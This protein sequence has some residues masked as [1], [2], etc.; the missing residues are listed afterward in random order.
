MCPEVNFF[1]NKIKKLLRGNTYIFDKC[2]VEKSLFLDILLYFVVMDH[3]NRTYNS[4]DLEK[5]SNELKVQTLKQELEILNQ[6]CNFLR[7]ELQNYKL[8]VN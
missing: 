6:E 4:W 8:K 5:S 7:E 1:L 2:F 3:L